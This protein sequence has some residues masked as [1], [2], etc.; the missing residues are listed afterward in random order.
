MSTKGKYTTYNTYSFK[1]RYYVMMAQRNTPLTDSE[2]REMSMIGV[3][4]N[5]WV[6]RNSFGNLA[7]L[8]YDKSEPDTTGFNRNLGFR[9]A[10]ITSS[11][12]DFTIYGGRNINGYNEYPAVMYVKGWYV[13]LSSNI[14]YSDQTK[15]VSKI[16]Q[17]SNQRSIIKE[18]PS[19]IVPNDT[20]TENEQLK[21]ATR[22]DWYVNGNAK[23]DA[24]VNV[25]NGSA[26]LSMI[27]SFDE[28][29]EDTTKNE[30]FQFTDPSIKDPVLANATAYRRRASVSFTYTNSSDDSN[31]PT[32]WADA[33]KV[34]W[35][36]ERVIN[37]WFKEETINGIN[38]I[39][40]PL[41][42][43]KVGSSGGLNA[44]DTKFYDLL[45]YFNK[46]VKAPEETSYV[47]SNG[48]YTE[49]EIENSFKGATG[50]NW[51]DSEKWD[52]EGKN[53]GLSSQS[54]NDDSVTPRILKDDGKYHMGSLVVGSED[55]GRAITNDPE[56]LNIGEKA[57][58]TEY[59]KKLYAGEYGSI[60]LNAVRAILDRSEVIVVDGRDPSEDLKPAQ[61]W[62][63]GDDSGPMWEQDLN[64]DIVSKLTNDG[65]LVLGGEDPAG[66]NYSLS[67][68]GDSNVSG[69]S[70]VDGITVEKGVLSTDSGILQNNKSNQNTY[71]RINSVNISI[72]GSSGAWTFLMPSS[73]SQ[74]ITAI[75]HYSYYKENTDGSLILIK[76]NR[77]F[78]NKTLNELAEIYCT[79]DGT[80]DVPVLTINHYWPSWRIHCNTETTIKI[81]VKSDLYNNGT[82]PSTMPTDF[83]KTCESSSLM[84][85]ESWTDKSTLLIQHVQHTQGTSV[86]TIYVLPKK[87]ITFLTQGNAGVLN[88]DTL[89]SPCPSGWFGATTLYPITTANYYD[90]STEHY[91]SSDLISQV[92]I[93]D[94]EKKASVKIDVDGYMG[95]TAPTMRISGGALQGGGYSDIYDITVYSYQSTIHGKMTLYADTYNSES[96]TFDKRLTLL[97]SEQDYSYAHISVSGGYLAPRMLR[98]E[99]SSLHVLTGSIFTQDYD[100]DQ[101]DYS[102]YTTDGDISTKTG[103]VYSSSG[104]LYSETGDIN[105]K[106]GSLIIGK[107]LVSN[108]FSYTFASDEGIYLIPYANIKQSL[109]MNA[110]STSN[111]LSFWTV[112]STLSDLNENLPID[113]I[114]TIYNEGTANLQISHNN[115]LI[116]L[117]PSMCVI[118]RRLGYQAAGVSYVST[119]TVLWQEIKDNAV[120]VSKLADDAVETA[121]IKDLNVSIGK[122]DSTAKAILKSIRTF[123]HCSIVP[124][125][126]DGGG[127]TLFRYFVI[128]CEEIEKLYVADQKWK[129]SFCINLKFYNETDASNFSRFRILALD[130]YQEPYTGITTNP[131]M[132]SLSIRGRSDNSWLLES[133]SDFKNQYYDSDTKTLTYYGTISDVD[134][135]SLPD[136]FSLSTSDKL[137]HFKSLAKVKSIMCFPEFNNLRTIGTITFSMSLTFERV[138]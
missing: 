16:F 131:W 70:V 126:M 42:F 122:I 106:A 3:D 80:G 111:I 64:G 41:C 40:V 58:N 138:S 94:P 60:P 17:D 76:G 57:A 108:S 123:N 134:L 113:S 30:G 71:P 89:V 22:S 35:Y 33:Q 127:E 45:S 83:V 38:Q 82:Q 2:I 95:G 10:P 52:F 59:L 63:S 132:E 6:A 69:N 73:D 7:V 20:S 104:D 101:E 121:K 97:N 93:W 116:T 24:W 37:S 43:V 26:V 51:S 39:T 4:L 44:A 112:F 1:K 91:E 21:Y 74:G 56:E 29:V 124:V 86:D 31:V 75:F 54:F 137:F 100:S 118:L 135:T 110:V 67:V 84:S 12:G 107:N 85:F 77:E 109:Y 18:N 47:L 79:F 19:E 115:G 117:R 66:D 133:G 46:R 105:C 96:E 129:I 25:P 136:A 34:D 65:R 62:L 28:V 48:N 114:I 88:E 61:L 49:D 5:R 81:L 36:D 13:F 72:G 8:A 125:Q 27:L 55:E 120:N 119:F 102:I 53:Q 103:D 128:N 99:D 87:G 78:P 11:P 32:T 92:K 98:I 14:N 68:I 130:E 50:L 23:N 15:E 9:C 90:S